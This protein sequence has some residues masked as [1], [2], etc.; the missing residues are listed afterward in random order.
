MQLLIAVK[1]VHHEGAVAMACLV[2]SQWKTG[3]ALEGS[4]NV[5]CVIRRRQ[6]TKGRYVVSPY[7]FRNQ[8]VNKQIKCDLKR[9]KKL[10]CNV[11]FEVN[12]C[13]FSVG[14]KYVFCFLIWIQSPTTGARTLDEKILR[15]CGNR[16]K[17][18]VKTALDLR[19]PWSVSLLGFLV[20]RQTT[21]P[22]H[23]PLCV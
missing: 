19:L 13:V 12:E 1:A 16:W 10:Y 2:D 20:G 22:K 7:Q 3:P 11:S 23:L 18:Y 21:D 15:C 9:L 6:K 14:C 8:S 5:M 17:R 4:T